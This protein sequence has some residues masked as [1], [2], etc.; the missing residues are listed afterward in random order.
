MT[1]RP[2]Q[3]NYEVE[4][5]EDVREGID[6]D[7]PWCDNLQ[8]IGV[9]GCSCVAAASNGMLLQATGGSL[10]TAQDSDEF[11]VQPSARVYKDVPI[12][13]SN[14]QKRSDSGR[15]NCVSEP[16]RLNGIVS[17]HACRDS[18]RASPLAT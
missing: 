18:D 1:Y 2:D 12:S 4:Q 5:P 10:S 6:Q 16:N 15:G 7:P 17:I 3:P 11:R 14:T 9:D 13:S 8:P